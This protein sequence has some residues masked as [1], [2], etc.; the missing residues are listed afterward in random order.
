M[1]CC[2]NEKSNS[3]LI[4]LVIWQRMWLLNWQVRQLLLKR[5]TV[6]WQ[7]N[8]WVIT[9]LYGDFLLTYM[10]T[11]HVYKNNNKYFWDYLNSKWSIESLNYALMVVV[12]WKW[13][14]IQLPVNYIHI[15]FILWLQYNTMRVCVYRNTLNIWS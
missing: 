10:Y 9:V 7:W 13:E 8:Y 14:T 11:V 1:G 4:S 5:T 2:I 6:V 12:Q 15:L 3:K